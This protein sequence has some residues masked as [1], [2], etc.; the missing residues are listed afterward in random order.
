MDTG[1]NLLIISFFLYQLFVHNTA[2]P[3]SVWGLQIPDKAPIVCAHTHTGTHTQTHSIRL[4]YRQFV[5][6]DSHLFFFISTG[7]TYLLYVRSHLQGTQ[8]TLPCT[9]WHIVSHTCTR[10]HS[11]RYTYT[12]TRL[13]L[14]SIQSLRGTNY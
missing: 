10:L 14:S 7:S 3:A 8:V 2:L 1:P 9:Q 4:V 6:T 12:P 5:I 13:P 11:C